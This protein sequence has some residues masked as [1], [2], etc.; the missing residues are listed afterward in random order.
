MNRKKTLIVLIIALLILAACGAGGGAAFNR[1]ESPAEPPAPAGSV[2]GGE[3]G[4]ISEEVA[5]DAVANGPADFDAQVAQNN[6]QQPAQDRLIIRTGNLDIVVRDTEDSL[7]AVARLAER[8]GGWVVSSEVRQQTET[9]KSGTITVRIPAEQYDEAVAQVKELATE[10]RWESSNSQDVT[11]EYVDLSARLENLEATADRVRAFLDEARNVEEALAVNQQLSQ[12][13]GEI[14][15]LKGRLQ[16]LSQSAA[17]STLTVSLTPDELFQ[18]I[19]VAGWRPEGVARDAIEAL[20]QTLQ[21]LANV[22]IW[23]AVY[24]LPLA[25]VLGL[26]GW[27]VVRF[28]RRW[29]LRRRASAAPAA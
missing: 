10:V 8:M 22:G 4:A 20:V 5:A 7:A 26:P 28:L 1:S 16:Y 23:L 13:E 17:Y 6:L 14:E 9:A 24:A 3:G 21:G 11:E 15:V 12:L 27:L 18:P 2:F 25:L 19:E 29:W